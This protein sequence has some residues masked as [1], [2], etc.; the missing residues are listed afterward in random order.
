MV[1]K[2]VPLFCVLSF[3]SLLFSC[4][5][6][7]NTPLLINFSKD[8]SA[9]V[10]KHIDPAGLLQLQNLPAGDSTLS[11]MVYVSELVL[12]VDSAKKEQLLVG[13]VCV[14]DSAVLFIPGRPFLKGQDY[15][16][17]SYLNVQFGSLKKMLKNEL[18]YRV[19]PQEKILRR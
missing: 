6:A 11:R 7:N 19:K 16:V 2:S 18:A 10:F 8:S 3:L 17:V 12:S 4:S 14:N 5:S 13:K 15:R 1:I 9:V